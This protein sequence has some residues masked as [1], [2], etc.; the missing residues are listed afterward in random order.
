MTETKTCPKCGAELPE[1][2]PAGLCPKCLMQAGLASEPSAGANPEVEPTTR[3]TGFVPPETEE[4]AEAF[5]QLE[6]LELLGQGGMGAVYTARQPGLDRLVAL[7]ILPPEVGADPAFAE[8]FTREARALGQLN[9]PNIVQVYDFGQVVRSD[10]IHRVSELEQD[11]VEENRM[12]AVTTNSESAPLYYF[13]MEYVDGTNLRNVIQ[14]GTI[15]PAEALAI[16][17]Q[18]CDA[19]QYAHDQGVV[20]RDIKPENILVDKQGRVK[21]AD[22]GLAKLM[23]K[24]PS[25]FTLTGSRQVMGT[26][27]YMAPEQ[28]RGAHDVDHRADIYS[29]GVV[30][31][32]MLT[33]ELPIGRFDPPSRKVQVDVRLDEVVLHALESQP[34][35]RYQHVSEV[36]TDVERVSQRSHSVAVS[37]ADTVAIPP[38]LEKLI[39]SHLPDN[40]MAAIKLYREKTGL[41]LDQAAMAIELIAQRHGIEFPRISLRRRLA[42]GAIMTGILA[43]YIAGYALLRQ[44]VHLSS[45]VAGSI[46]YILILSGTAFFAIS[47]WRYRRYRATRR[48]QATVLVAGLFCFSFVVAPLLE[49]LAEPEP[50]LNWL[51]RVSGATPGEHDVFFFHT[52]FAIFI[53]GT[54]A[55][56]VRFWRRLRRTRNGS[57]VARP[58]APPKTDLEPW[59]VVP[60]PDLFRRVTKRTLRAITIWAALLGALNAGYLSDADWYFQKELPYQYLE[61]GFVVASGLVVIY[62]AWWWYLLAKPAETPRSFGEFWRLLQQRPGRRLLGGWKALVVYVGLYWLLIPWVAL[63]PESDSLQAVYMTSLL[64]IGPF[65]LMAACRRAYRERFDRLWAEGRMTR[66]PVALA[67]LLVSVMIVGQ[68]LVTVN[69]GRG[70][71]AQG[72]F[73]PPPKPLAAPMPRLVTVR[74]VDRSEAEKRTPGLQAFR[75]ALTLPPGDWDCQVFTELWREG[76][77]SRGPIAIPRCRNPKSFELRWQQGDTLSPEGKGKVRWDW[78]AE[79]GKRNASSES[80]GGWI[81]DPFADEIQRISTWRGTEQWQWGPGE[82]HTLLILKG[83]TGSFSYPAYAGDPDKLAQRIKDENAHANVELYLKIRIR[84][85]R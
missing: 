20:H 18:I 21:I 6:I 36:K 83:H 41:S 72:G 4:L 68:L 30:F 73:V 80:T 49:V 69:W 79:L 8:R 33:G 75:Y 48:Y 84:P 37:E 16:V 19:L 63:W 81:D 71:P 9:H 76:K 13:I 1:N 25:E 70:T 29:L 31:Y 53:F 39:L 50:L 42:I 15:E 23:G 27:H 43:L 2:A 35:R 56:L 64:M 57:P 67:I 65:V 85:A 58:S 28:M 45:V 46:Y 32:E 59:G 74:E 5:P 55:W 77:Q 52:L 54:L 44:Y 22:F 51:Y 10:P 61:S 12:N 34:E 40:M 66:L 3:T 62:L 7:K 11:M 47:A 14:S 60:A 26:V 78:R 17:P 38:E 82:D 24:P